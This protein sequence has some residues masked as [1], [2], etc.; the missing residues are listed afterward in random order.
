MFEREIAE[1]FGLKPIG[2]PWLKPVRY[3]RCPTGR[4][5][6]DRPL[7]QPILPAVGDFSASKATRYMK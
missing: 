1:Q 6:W 3:H 5:A 4:D 7:D 2:H